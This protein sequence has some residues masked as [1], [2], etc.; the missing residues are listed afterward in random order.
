MKVAKVLLTTAGLASAV[1]VAFATT[2]LATP[3]LPISVSGT[4]TWPHV[5]KEALTITGANTH[6]RASPSSG[7]LAIAPG[8]PVR[9]TVTNYTREYHTITIPGLHVSALIFPARGATPRKTTFTFTSSEYGTFAW[10]CAYCTSGAHGHRHMMG[11]TIY[12]I[13]N[14][15]VLP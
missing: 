12:A 11:G 8:V 15:S 7:N 14:P 9:V 13:I 4:Q 1:A 10:Y 2:A 3:A 5:Q 6:E